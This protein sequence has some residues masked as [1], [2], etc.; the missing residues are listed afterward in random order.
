M[1]VRSSRR[2]RAARGTT[3]VEL[4]VTIVVIGVITAVV[5]LALPALRASV[6]NDSLA[7]IVAARKEAVER[8]QPV[9]ITMLIDGQPADATALADG[10]VVADSVAGI[11]R[12]TGRKPNAKR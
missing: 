4:T 8:S 9:T 7:S 2:R 3:L 12:M 11:D 10:S 6:P 5:A 1:S